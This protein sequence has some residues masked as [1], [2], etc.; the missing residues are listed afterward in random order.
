MLLEAACHFD[1]FFSLSFGRFLELSSNFCSV[2]FIEKKLFSEMN[3]LK[4]L[5]IPP[6]IDEC[7]QLMRSCVYID[8]YNGCVDVRSVSQVLTPG[9]ILGVCGQIPFLHDTAC[10]YIHDVMSG[11][12][13]EVHVSNQ[14]SNEMMQNYHIL[15]QLPYY[16]Y[17][18]A[19]CDLALAALLN[20]II[21]SMFGP[22]S[23]HFNKIL[24]EKVEG[25]CSMANI[26]SMKFNFPGLFRDVMNTTLTATPG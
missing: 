20:A 3:P 15:H 22:P 25:I 9:F 2:G 24:G 1:Y 21:Y 18:P 17:T 23:Q 6:S 26:Y 12:V 16:S 13:Y 19:E 10:M 8:K 11:Q 5:T 14:H 7:I 4:V